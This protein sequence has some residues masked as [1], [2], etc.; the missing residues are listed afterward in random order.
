MTKKHLVGVRPSGRLHIGH[1]A[2][3]IKPAIEHEADILIAE[4]H[5]PDITHGNP[6]QSTILKHQ[7]E[8][9]VKPSQIKYQSRNFE[10][11][12]FFKLLEVTPS[13]LLK[14]MPQ[15]K[16]KEKNALMFSYPVLMAYDLIGY[17]YVIVGDDQRP[18]IEFA[19]DI[20]PKIGRKC[21]K[22]IYDGG[23][24]MDLRHPERKMSKSEP[25]SCLFL[26][27]KDY[28]KKIMKAVTNF[29]GLENL[30][31]I[32]MLLSGMKN[33]RNLTYNSSLSLKRAIIDL[34]ERK[35]IKGK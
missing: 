14:H 15:Y 13:G 33:T 31:N 5:A 29:E 27:D 12:L 20:L 34:Y 26:D 23:K 24:I 9:F 18:H 1:Y 21:P 11:M 6:K 28:E 25:S 7:L 17:D 19:N 3:V 32:Y 22:A 35:F 4:Y 16:E 10:P 30:E 2:S 8:K